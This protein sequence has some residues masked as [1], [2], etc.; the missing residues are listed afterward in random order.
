MVVSADEVNNLIG[1]KDVV[2]LD[3]RRTGEYTG[4]SRLQWKPRMGR[5]PGAIGL[6]WTELLEGVDAL[7]AFL[8]DKAIAL[9][10]RYC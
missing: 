7:Q 9:S 1:S 3:V 8:R 2:L 10:S 4:L 5:I 6:E